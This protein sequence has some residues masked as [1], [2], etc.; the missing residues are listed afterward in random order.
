[1]ALC[2]NARLRTVIAEAL[3]STGAGGS[4][5]VALARA[6]TLGQWLRECWHEWLLR[7]GEPADAERLLCD[8][9]REELAW[10][11][12]L[13]DLDESFAGVAA[14]ASRAERALRLYRAPMRDERVASAFRAERDGRRF[15]EWRGQW[16]E[17]CRR[18]ALLSEL[19]A[20][21]RLTAAFASGGMPK[22]P[23]IALVG[24]RPLAP[25]YAAL[26][27][28]AAERLV[29]VG[30]ACREPAD[31]R[32]VE[33]ADERDELASAAL[34]AAERLSSE[35]QA[36]VAVAVP[37][38]HR[39]RREVDYVFSAVL[40]DAPGAP[41]YRI[42]AGAPLADAPMVSAA[43]R[44]LGLNAGPLALG[45]AEALLRSPFFAHGRRAGE[46]AAPVQ[47][48]AWIDALRSL[49]RDPLERAELARWPLARPP[50]L[51]ERM[52]AETDR[53]PARLG[54]AEWV[55]RFERQ[56][57]RVGWPGCRKLD[58]V[59]HQQRE[60]FGELLAEAAVR[61]GLCAPMSAERA[62]AALRAMAVQAPFQPQRARE[63][64]VRVDIIDPD[65]GVGLG[66]DALWMAGMTDQNWP[67]PPEP[68]AFIPLELQR[69]LG[70][71]EAD[72]TTQLE[73]AAALLADHRRSAES[74]WCS[75]A[76]V[77]DHGPARPSALLGG[78][79]PADPARA[80]PW[81]PA[82]LAAS[83]P[84]ERVALEDAPGC[85][86]AERAGVSA[87]ALKLQSD[88]PFRAWAERRLGARAS[89][90]PAAG[91]DAAQRGS[92]VH[93][94]LERLW[95]PFDDSAALL[96]DEAVWR[97]ALDRACDA[98]IARARAEAPA[99][100]GERFW[101]LERARLV[102][103]LSRWVEQAERAEHAR[104]P[105]RVIA[106]EQR[107]G[108][109][110][111]GVEFALRADRVDERADGLLRL[112]DYKTGAPE[113][114]GW[115][116]ERPAEPQLPLYALLHPG[117]V[118]AIAYGLLRPDA[119]RYHERDWDAVDPEDRRDALSR[120]AGE[121]AAGRCAVAP[122]SGAV[123]RRCA[124]GGLCRIRSAAADDAGGDG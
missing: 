40:G 85:D 113:S 3:G 71:D 77:G 69:E 44:S 37:G 62:L 13:S 90:A 45:D 83:G 7:S 33:C 60:R 105:F 89:D 9:A 31:S 124:L 79:W 56:L 66:F 25:L 49:R 73:R 101:R 61:G 59:E 39:R 14:P 6:Q 108:G 51:F 96:A 91:L 8:A 119:A 1:M 65:G 82:W 76:R 64:E 121:Y 12:L 2:A 116:G 107:F 95:E 36:R 30:M 10:Q 70:I 92:L 78:D 75:Y 99:S 47:T 35:P 106:T 32:V 53:A 67:P 100:L 112:V 22:R 4:G 17:F 20:A 81:R 57:K 5:A 98:A 87:A 11:Q 26:V 38:L 16:L 19:A 123:C 55:A 88:C 48:A 97:A 29:V 27:E 104:A 111:G 120:L 118:G 102:D 34:W 28:A 15:L 24:F 93:W 109:R 63:R 23:C 74:V 46:A 94:A 72:A 21:E 122:R 18:R 41:T 84:F 80:R 86:D 68:H 114:N 54:L 43:L 52:L 42:A 103:A 115:H 58:S 117:P 50:A 110:L